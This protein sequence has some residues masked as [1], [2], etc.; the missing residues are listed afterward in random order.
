MV[1]LPKPSARLR[2]CARLA[3]VFVVAFV[4]ALLI[5]IPL[6]EAKLSA[7]GDSPSRELEGVVDVNSENY[8]DIVGHDQF[9]LLE[10]Y[11]DWCGY[12]REFVPVYE[13]FGKYVRIRPE[14]SERLVVGKVNA[15]QERRI[16]RRYKVDGYPTV[17]LVPPNSHE[18]IEYT[19]SR[20]F[21]LILSFIERRALKDANTAE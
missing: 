2:T 20:E 10:F 11:A 8:Y 4:L 17:I 18:G 16:Q 3:V 5:L 19:D 21:N 15:P 7:G 12:C 1:L 14:L 6:L 9:V 13:E